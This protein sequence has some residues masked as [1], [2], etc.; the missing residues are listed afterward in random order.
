MI[1]DLKPGDQMDLNVL[2]NSYEMKYSEKVRNNYF[3]SMLCKDS[4]GEIPVKVFDLPKNKLDE[5]TELL[6]ESKFIHIQ[7]NVEDFKG[8]INVKALNIEFIEEPEDM[9]YYEKCAPIELN[10]LKSRLD[11]AIEKIEKL[12]FKKLVQS[13][14]GKNGTY[15]DKFIVWPAAKS[16]HHAYRHGLL[17]H[18]LEV[19]SFVES[20]FDGYQ[21]F[22]PSAKSD[23]INWD[24]LKTAAL[25]HDIA[26]IEE[27]DYDNG[28]TNYTVCGDLI[29]HLNYGAMWAFHNIQQIDNFPKEESELLLHILL[30]HH[31]RKDWGAAIEPKT[32]EAEFF[33]YADLRSA[34]ANKALKSKTQG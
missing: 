17:Q 13:M 20:D 33:H 8:N 32:I 2:V 10:I 31:G 27:L 19:F 3:L 16:M 24:A 21:K 30:S 7:G 18:S 15:R 34:A 25:I 9:S 29:G 26:K 14:I 5:L 28:I 23:N 11:E 1:A 12:H 22:D 4:S 6:D